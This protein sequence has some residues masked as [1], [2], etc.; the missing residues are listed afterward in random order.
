MVKRIIGLGIF[1]L[2]F[3]LNLF[4]L[5]TLE[6]KQSSQET[7]A[8]QSDIDQ[9]VVES[10]AIDLHNDGILQQ[11]TEVSKLLE[12]AR[13]YPLAVSLLFLLCNQDV[14][15]SPDHLLSCCLSFSPPKDILASYHILRI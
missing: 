10:G 2:I 15:E 14:E 13:K 6:A 3:S 1:A 11:N 12:S 7:Y 8:T 4:T 5:G 9:E